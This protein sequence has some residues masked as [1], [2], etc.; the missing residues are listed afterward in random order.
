MD[1]KSKEIKLVDVESII[2]NYLSIQLNSKNPVRINTSYAEI[3]CTYK[4][5]GIWV[6]VDFED[7]EKISKIK[8]KYQ[9]ST[10]SY[11]Q[12]NA[13]LNKTTV[14][15]SRYLLKADKN[16]YVDHVNGDPT[17]NRKENIRFCTLSQ[18]S[19]NRKS[20][21]GRKYKGIYFCKSRKN[22]VAQISID[23]KTRNIGR[24]KT[25]KQAAIA[26]NEMAI[27]HHGE[28]ARINKI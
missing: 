13:S 19:Q 23:G 3:F 12:V 1:I 16:Q 25:D 4:A 9:P 7:L 5:K 2:P 6:K 26:Y 14:L 15:M 21:I 24:F 17:D 27:K 28:F 8:W 20:L 10:D 18:N 11:N 22:W